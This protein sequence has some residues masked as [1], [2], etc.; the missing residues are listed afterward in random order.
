MVPSVRATFGWIGQVVSWLVILGVALALAVAVI[1]PRLAG[2]TPYTVLT[3]SMQPT[4]PPGTL[5]VVKPT[6]FDELAIGDVVTYQRESGK[7]TV[8]T[9][10]VV[11]TGTRFDG[12]RTVTTRGDANQDPDRNPVLAVQVKGK[13]W[14]AVP[15]LGYV[16]NALSGQERQWAVIAVSALLIGYAAFMFVSALRDRR[17]AKRESPEPVAEALG[18]PMEELSEE[19]GTHSS[20]APPPPRTGTRSNRRLA[21]VMVG[22]AGLV[23]GLVL[24]RSRHH[25]GREQTGRASS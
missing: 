12:T 23:F 11:G 1:I 25:H 24:I 6:D 5:V 18:M 7:S 19:Q 4:Y 2:A 15:Y 13:L 8:V 22:T 16:N 14:Y 20:A 10:R 17:R 9:H 21:P 3:G